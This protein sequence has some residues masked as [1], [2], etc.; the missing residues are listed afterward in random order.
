M[1]ESCITE[2]KFLDFA[3]DLSHNS[4]GGWTL[5]GYVACGDYYFQLDVDGKEVH[6]VNKDM[7]V[8]LSLM[9]DTAQGYLLP[10]KKITLRDCHF[11][12]VHRDG[13]EMLQELVR[14][15]GAKEVKRSLREI[16]LSSRG[17]VEAKGE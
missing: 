13:Y 17:M 2:K 15:V 1:I 16:K 7:A 9:I 8:A 14:A 4:K 10:E 6:C 11:R 12:F 3:H 5:T